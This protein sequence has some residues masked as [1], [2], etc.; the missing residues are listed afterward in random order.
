MNRLFLCLWFTL[1]A[2]VVGGTEAV[3]GITDPLVASTSE[4]PTYYVIMNVANREFL[5]HNSQD[6]DRP[7]T[8]ANIIDGE[9][10][11]TTFFPKYYKTDDYL[12]YFVADGNGYKIAPKNPNS[13]SKPYVGYWHLEGFYYY[14]KDLE[15]D[16][17]ATTWTIEKF[18]Y[19]QLGVAIHGISKGAANDYYW[20]IRTASG[21]TYISRDTQCQTDP[22][23]HTFVLYSFAD[24]QAEAAAQGLTDTYTYD[25]SNPGGSF[26][27]IVDDIIATKA[28][29]NHYN[30]CDDGYYLVRNRRNGLFLTSNGEEVKGAQAVTNYSVW[31]LTTVANIRMLVSNVGE[32][33]ALCWQA[34]GSD[35]VWNLSAN[36]TFNVNATLSAASDG[37]LRY[38][39][40]NPAGATNGYVGQNGDGSP[41]A[42]SSKG[43]SSDWQLIAVTKDG[44]TLT[45]QEDGVTKT[46]PTSVSGDSDLLPAGDQQTN[47]Q[48]Y[49][50][51]NMA[52]NIVNYSADE[53]G[54]GGWLEDVDH[55]HFEKRRDE[56]LANLWDEEEANRLYEARTVDFYAALPDMSHASALWEF[57]LIGKGDNT[58]E[59][60]TGIVLPKHNIF[61]LRNANTGKFI[62][63][64]LAGDLYPTTAADKSGAM[65][66][67]L[68]KQ[69][70]GQYA[71]KVYKGTSGGSDVSDHVLAIAGTADGYRA[72]L[73]SI[74]TTDTP[75]ALWAITQATTLE[76]PL[77]VRDVKEADGTTPSPYDWT[78]MYFPFDTTLGTLADGQEVDFFQGG[79]KGTYTYGSGKK[80][81][82]VEMTKVTDV[83]AGNA[84]FMRSNK[85]AGGETYEMVRL[86]VYP[87]NS[88]QTVTPQSTFEGNVWKGI[89]ESEESEYWNGNTDPR[90]KDY[91][92]LTKN[93]SG[94]LKLLHPA[95][96]YLLGNRAYID[97]E[98]AV[99]NSGANVSAFELLID[100]ADPVVTGVTEY[101]SDATGTSA[102][103][104]I[105]GRKVA[106][107]REQ[108]NLATKGIYI[109]NG[110]KFFVK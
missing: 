19:S 57:V 56:R 65:K 84:V 85:T 109:C 31:Q 10:F 74:A 91:W 69:A 93:G 110:K 26:K 81:G 46:I 83:P 75:N 100:E 61:A 42:S 53:P 108:M 54:D 30:D 48:F 15:A 107:S 90:K 52:R 76:L 55:L 3:A 50:V 41:S 97:A 104:D 20:T 22:D 73:E 44:T 45:Y 2:V 70:D 103:Y 36:N 87:A 12:W 60:A 29:A 58:G 5:Y 68:D 49:R 8:T 24:L 18:P 105:T 39:S 78:T 71:L 14:I 99:V 7:W 92:I 33:T 16:A 37:D 66:F 102:V 32:G 23:N 13:A 9:N 98:T 62:G 35:A 106:D 47:G 40:F 96:N 59:S 95:N 77:L 28:D 17:D 38:V 21:Y 51:Q 64:T 82:A 1:L 11:G 43:Y 94:I 63:N 101:V 27:T 79:W 86:N 80:G 25:A 6:N 67:Y 34:N 4:A 88:G 72:G 89:I